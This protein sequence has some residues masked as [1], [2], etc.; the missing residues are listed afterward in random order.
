[1]EILTKKLGEGQIKWGGIVIPRS[2]KALFP[3]PGVEFDLWEG[4]TTYKA[5]MDNQSRLRV[6]TWFRQ[7]RS[8]KEGDEVTFLKEDGKIYVALSKNFLEPTKGVINWAQEVIE[9]IKDGEV[10]GI[11]RMNKKGFTVEIGDHIKKTQIIL[12]TT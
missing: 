6:A 8:I 1:M 10:H 2:K 7:H 12:G 3:S 11:I 5:K 9:A 4:K